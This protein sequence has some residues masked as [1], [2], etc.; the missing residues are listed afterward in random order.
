MSLVINTN[1]IATIATNNL[2]ANQVNL[3]RSLARLS[4]GSKIVAP[5]DDAGG[6]A[7]STK[8]KAALNRNTRTQQNVSN[9]ISFMQTQDGAL[10]VATNILD[11]MSELK[12]M[13][14]DPTKND[15]DL[16]N[17]N[18][19]FKEL[20]RQLVNINDERFNGINLFHETS[21][22]SVS[23]TEDGVTGTVN[24]TRNGLFDN[25]AKSGLAQT[26]IASA[27][28]VATNNTDK[29][30]LTIGTPTHGKSAEITLDGVTGSSV[31]G[32]IKEI[33]KQLALGE[34]TSVTARETYDGRIEL[35][36]SEKFTVSETADAGGAYAGL[37]LSADNAGTASTYDTIAHTYSYQ[38][39]ANYAV[40]DVVSGTRA[41]GSTETYLVSS[42]VTGIGGSFDSFAASANVTRLD[43]SSNP[44]AQVLLRD[45][46]ATYSQGEVVYNDDDGRYYV[47]TAGTTT[48]LTAGQSVFQNSGD[49]LSLGGGLPTVSNHEA[50]DASKDYVT[51]DIVSFDG[52]LYLA[53]TGIGKGNQDPVQNGNWTKIDIAVSGRG[54]L[55]DESNDLNDFLTS[56][57]IDFLQTAATTRAQNGAELQRLHVSNEMLETNYQNLEAANSRLQDVDIAKESTAFARFN[58]LVQSA[59]A[60]LAQA[61]ASQNVALQLLQ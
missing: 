50:F 57:F 18:T 4:S 30:V 20:Q 58:I 51:N 7:V 40:G 6:L 14:I 55:L 16:A 9:A 34:I 38:G 46:A 22:L 42:A 10:K 26:V 1:N 11:R 33:N 39:L 56:D 36:G 45:G 12:T 61:N 52:N 23:S 37:G 60:M 41:D 15:Y 3:Q 21:D 28:Y 43:N 8:L 29:T 35:A 2:N 44:N 59:A 54:N 19:E 17:Y 48:A 24:M 47:A 5:H 49:F 32:A 25:L 13:S 53:T 31:T 27:A